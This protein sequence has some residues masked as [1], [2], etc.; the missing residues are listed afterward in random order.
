M[1]KYLKKEQP[2]SKIKRFS[3]FVGQ[4]RRFPCRH[5]GLQRLVY[6]IH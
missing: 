4:F 5:E 6:V 3:F 2:W 1:K